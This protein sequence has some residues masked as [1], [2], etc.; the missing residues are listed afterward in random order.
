MVVDICTFDDASI[1]ES[2]YLGNLRNGRADPGAGADPIHDLADRRNGRVRAPRRG[3][4][5]PAADRLRAVQ[6]APLPLRLGRRHRRQRLARPRRRGR[7][8]ATGEP[9][10]VGAGLLPGRAGLRRRADGDEGGRRRPA[11]DGARRWAGTL[12]PA[13]PRRGDARGARPRR[14][15]PPHP[16]RLPRPVLG[17][18]LMQEL[19]EAGRPRRVG[20]KRR[21]GGSICGPTTSAS[22]PT[23]SR[24]AARIRRAAHRGR[25]LRRQLRSRRAHGTRR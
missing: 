6:R 10:L 22:A 20:P 14:G 15:A 12:V 4:P 8:R 23:R 19:S 25:G 21:G 1:V 7:P 18:G 11:V 9:G 17:G 5:R 16:L 24:P 2:L 3:G 13:R